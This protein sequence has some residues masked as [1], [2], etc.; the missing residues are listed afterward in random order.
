MNF[1]LLVISLI[2]VSSFVGSAF[3]QNLI[4]QDKISPEDVMNEI[5][6]KGALI[7][8]QEGSFMIELFPEDAPNHVYHFLKLIESGY[9]E[10]TIF[11]RIIPEFMIQ[12]GDPNTK[13]PESDR[14]TWGQ[15]GPGYDIDNEINTIK[16]KRGI[17]SMARYT[18]VDTAQSQFFI[19]TQDSPHLNGEYTAFG[20]LVPGTYSFYN[21]DQI[22][23]LNT[24]AKDAPVD[25]SEAKIIKTEVINYSGSGY[26]LPPERLDSVIRPIKTGG[27]NVEQYIS[28]KYDTTFNLPYR[29]SVIET[30]GDLLRLELKPDEYN[31]SVKAAVEKSGFIPQIFVAQEERGSETLIDETGTGA[32]FVITNDAFFSIKDADEPVVLSN[33]LFENDD[34]R[35]G[36]ILVTTQVLQTSTEPIKFKIIQLHFTN[37]KTNYAVIY[38][39]VIDFFA[40]E[41]NAFDQTVQDFKTTIDGKL[42]PIN[43][44][45][46][47]VYK[48]IIIEGRETPTTE[49]P[50]P[51]EIGGCLIATASYGSELAPQVQQLRELR[52]Y[53]VLQTKSGSIFMAGFNQ[54]YYSFSPMIADY[55]RE[56]PAFKEGVKLAITPLLTSL[57][58]LQHTNIN[59]EYEM[60]GYGI[61]I[62]LLNIGMYIIAPAVLIMK[63]RSFY[64]LQ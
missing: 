46:S 41:I 30:S 13:D 20:R 16:H 3:A 43:F 25:A 6:G 34:G 63:I 10:G 36:H 1:Q 7:T 21:L 17:V 14:T 57:T 19:V 24:D 51:Q 2:L 5:E 44:A 35:F 60:L 61:S 32:D 26:L 12:G 4:Q 27:G 55:E 22:A 64:K 42:Q 11:H 54:F 33:N 29:W 40:Y 56:N 39:N 45:S 47:P 8:T 18:D 53:T 59:S 28:E 37:L 23:D 15:G 49:L 50:P 62:I 31:H 52:D 38:V 9:Y 58:L 48:Y